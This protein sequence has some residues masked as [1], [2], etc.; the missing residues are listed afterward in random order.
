MKNMTSR[1]SLQLSLL[2]LAGWISPKQTGEYIA[3]VFLTP[4]R[5]PRP[6]WENELLDRSQEISLS[7]GRKAW[8]WG[9]SAQKILLVHGWEGR[10]TQL[11]SFIDPMLAAGF[12]VIA[13]D[14]P[15]HGDSP[16][17]QTHLPDFARAL[18]QDAK[19]LGPLHA[20]VAH[21]MG[22][23]ALM[24]AT[25]NGLQF[26]KSILI[27]SP[28]EWAPV[29]ETLK[30][31]LN[32][33]KPTF[34][35]L[36]SS[37]EKTIGEPMENFDVEKWTLKNFPDALIIHDEKDRDVS[38]RHFQRLTKAF[39]QARSKLYSGLGHRRILRDEKVI[40]EILEFLEKDSL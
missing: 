17:S 24:L 33:R 9:H 23:A 4:K 8:T 10:G 3:R 35:A 30:Q 1:P 6:D 31:K 27:A 22:G 15:A 19:E 20:I 25:E 5:Y 18:T 16:G 36:K 12:Q 39:P 28:S 26:S 38:P 11:G 29:L 21:S 2:K 37:L 14:G 7:S 32:L 34:R 40:T 13:W